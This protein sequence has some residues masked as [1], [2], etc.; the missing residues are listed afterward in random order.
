MAQQIQPELINKRLAT[1]EDCTRWFIFL[2]IMV[3]VTLLLLTSLS[4]LYPGEN[5]TIDLSSQLVNISS[6]EVQNNLSQINVSY[7]G[8]IATI[9]IPGDYEPSSF[10]IIFNGYDEQNQQETVTHQS[11]GGGGCITT[12]DCSGWGECKEGK[13]TRTCTKKISYC[14]A[15][16]TITVQNCT[17]IT[18]TIIANETIDLGIPPV[19]SKSPPTWLFI[20]LIITAIILIIIIIAIVSAIRCV[21]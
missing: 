6:Y 17:I 7:N 3:F 21:M 10:K 1:I 16:P 4:A 9:F 20:L 11:S 18:S 12:W 13:Q 8:T 15:K 5:Y 19:E 14:Y 2:F